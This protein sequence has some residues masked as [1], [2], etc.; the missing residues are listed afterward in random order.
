MPCHPA[1]ARELLHSARA[2]V[3]RLARVL[4]H[5][6]APLADAAAVNSTRWAL[7]RRL[8]GADLPLSSGSGGRTKW[9]R[10]RLGIP[11]SH[12]L[13]ALCVGVVD[14]IYNWQLPVLSIK[15]CGRGSYK[16]TRLT[17]HGFPRGYLTR[18]KRIHGFQTGDRVRA[19]VRFGKQA[20]VHTGRVAVRATGSFNLQTITGTI[21]GISH[22]HCRRLQRA[23]GYTYHLTALLPSLKEGVSAPRRV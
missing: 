2:V 21:Q 18:Q 17:A 22:T 23:D 14:S 19:V 13:D 6:K 7:W 8:H 12:A 11:K 1:R 4:E 15:A 5:T 3:H 16:R 20:G 10:T 9:N